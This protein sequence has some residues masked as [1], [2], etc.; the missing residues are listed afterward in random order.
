MCA[1]VANAQEFEQDGICYQ[2]NSDNSTVTVVQ[3]FFGYSGD[4]VIPESVNYQGNDFNV[5]SIEKSAFM[6]CTGITSITIGNNVTSIGDKAFYKCTGLTSIIIPNSIAIIGNAAFNGCTGLRNITIPNSVTSIGEAMFEGCSELENITLGN[7]ITYIDK[8]AFS[9]SVN[10]EIFIPYWIYY[11]QDI[12][13]I[14]VLTEG[15]G[16]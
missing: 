5:V 15:N 11:Y 16:V 9:E 4:I 12:E 3:S 6:E 13:Y 14:P 1:M 10:V 7:C 2:V 8:K